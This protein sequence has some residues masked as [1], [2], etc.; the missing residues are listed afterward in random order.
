MG[1]RLFDVHPLLATFLIGAILVAM[2]STQNLAELHPKRS[3][4]VYLY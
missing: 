2:V 3:L 4:K 1:G